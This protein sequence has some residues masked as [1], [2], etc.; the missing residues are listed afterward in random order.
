[1]LTVSISPAEAAAMGMIIEAVESVIGMPAYQQVVMGH[2]QTIC[3]H[4]PG[5]LGCLLGY[6][7]HLGPRG[8]VLIEINTNAGGALLCCKPTPHLEQSLLAMFRQEWELAGT[9]RPLTRVAI[10]DDEPERQFLLPEFQLFQAL[11]QRHGIMAHIAAPE[12]LS[13]RDGHLWLEREI[14]DL[15]YNRLTD[16]TLA[17]DAHA[18]LREAYLANAVVV[19]PHPH[20]HAL[21]ADKRNFELLCNPEALGELGVSAE[22]SANLVGAIPQTTMV[23]AENADA[24]WQQRRQLF[25]K[26]AHGYG[27]KGTYNGEKL[28][29]RVWAQL[30]ESDYVAQ[31]RVPPSR[32][33]GPAGE[34][35]VDLRHYTYAGQTLLRAARLYRGQTT[36]LRTPGGGFARVEV[37]E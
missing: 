31:Q 30:P 6:D 1:M 28:T 14:V 17:E 11:F 4:D 27:S 24:L 18:P 15:V 22:L 33:I 35:K 10:I 9:G 19:T 20:A 32:L 16:F 8:P 13:Y 3:R 21:Y 7:F 36:N 23:K 5:P 37:G 26:P 25:F 2:A 29:R 34:L 12:Q